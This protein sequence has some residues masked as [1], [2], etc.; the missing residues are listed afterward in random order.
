MKTSQGKLTL[1]QLKDMDPHTMFA[2]GIA[3]DVPD[4]LYIAGTGTHLRWVA[5]RGGIH[6]W[7][8]YAQSIDWPEELVRA[9][10]DKVLGEENIRRLV[11]CTDKAFKM[12]RY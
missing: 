9:M 4:E 2:T 8:I 7:A 5:V 6:D 10:G 1:T 3:N 12:Y 11:P